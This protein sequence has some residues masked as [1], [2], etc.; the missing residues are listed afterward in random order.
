M[1]VANTGTA[2]ETGEI[3]DIELCSGESRRW[4]YLGPD[5]REQ[6]WWRDT[7]SGLEFSET[8]LMYAWHIAGK[9]SRPA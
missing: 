6:I 2:P 9:A 8:S 4:Q 5:G 7:E 3:Y 1:I